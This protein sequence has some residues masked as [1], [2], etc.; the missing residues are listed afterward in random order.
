MVIKQNITM[1][2]QH[3]RDNENQLRMLTGGAERVGGR[4]QG[5]EKSKDGGERGS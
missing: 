4:M 1:P 2:G 5:G 3:R